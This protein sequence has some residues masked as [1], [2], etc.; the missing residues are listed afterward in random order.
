[1]GSDVLFW[2]AGAH[3]DSIH[4]LK[5]KKSF[6]KIKMDITSS[7]ILKIIFVLKHI[8]NTILTTLF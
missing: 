1:M 4:A 7:T 2:P 5:K 8:Q 3:A 6:K